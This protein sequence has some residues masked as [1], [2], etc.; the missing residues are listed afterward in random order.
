MD[1]LAEALRSG[2]GIAGRGWRVPWVGVAAAAAVALAGVAA[3]RAGLPGRLKVKPLVGRVGSEVGEAARTAQDAVE[4]AVSAA[5]EVSRPRPAPAREP[6]SPA[7]ESRPRE[8]HR[9]PTREAAAPARQAKVTHPSTVDLEL[10]SSPPGAKVV[11]LDTGEL[12]GR[13]PLKLK[14]YQ[15]QRQV[16]LRFTLDGYEPAKASA[17][18]KSDRKV[19][20]T[21]RKSPRRRR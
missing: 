5:P 12:L 18:L 16:A 15:K 20:V 2:A 1:A 10:R 13:T 7:R 14:F 3:W 19:S 11:R 4:S 9:E 17:S 6:A 21:L 8:A